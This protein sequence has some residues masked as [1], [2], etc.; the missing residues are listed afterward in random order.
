LNN[1]ADKED[2]QKGNDLKNIIN[3]NYLNSAE[4][5]NDKY[6]ENNKTEKIDT[7]IESSFNQL[8]YV[9][10][11]SIIN[12]NDY[13]IINKVIVNE[14]KD[15][16]NKYNYKL[17]S[18]TYYGNKTLRILN[19]LSKYINEKIC[20]N[21]EIIIENITIDQY[22]REKK[23]KKLR[24]LVEDYSDTYYGLRDIDINKN[25]YRTN[26]LGLVLQGDIENKITQ[27]DGTTASYF[28]SY[29]GKIKISYSVT[30]IQTNSHII[31]RNTNEMVKCFINILYDL[32]KDL[33][34][35]NQNYNEIILNFEKNL[36]LLIDRNNLYDFSRV[37]VLPLNNMYNEV[38]NFTSNL[39]MDLLKIID[40][41][42]SNYTLLFSEIKEN[43]L[44]LF[45]EIKKITKKEYLDYIQCSMNDLENFKNNTLKYINE[46]EYLIQN[47]SN[48]QIDILYD[49]K[50]NIEE[51]K[52]IFK[53]F[54]TLLFNS[55]TKGIKIIKI[56]LSEYMDEIIGELL[57]ITEFISSGLKN[58]DI[59]KN[60][61]DENAKIKTIYKLQEFKII[62]ES[63]INTLFEEIFDEYDKEMLIS[64]IHSIKYLAE[65]KRSNLLEEINN[66]SNNLIE[67]IKLKIKYI[68]KYEL[69]S[70]NIDKINDINYNIENQLYS[71]AN[72][73][74][75]KN[76][77]KIEPEFLDE[78]SDI[79]NNK[80]KLF[81]ISILLKN[82]INNDIN[83]AN[84]YINT[85][86]NKYKN[87][88]I[89]HLYLNLSHFRKSFLDESMNNLL[90][91]FYKLINDTVKIHLKQAIKYNYDLGFEY[92]N[93]ELNYFNIYRH[94]RRE[95]ITTEFISKFYR[96]VENNKNFL[97]LTYSSD[98]IEIFEENFYNLRDEILKYVKDKISSINKYYFDNKLYSNLF[99]YISQV[100]NEILNIIDNINNY[101][102]EIKFDGE[103]QSY[104]INII[105]N[106]LPKYDDQLDKEFQ[107]LYNYIY[108]IS[109]KIKSDG[110]DFCW[111][112]WRTFKGWKNY[113]LYTE[114]T[115]NIEKVINNLISTKTYIINNKNKIY[116]NF[117]N[118][119]SKYLNS[120]INIS[121]NIFTNLFSYMENKINNCENINA[122]LK[123]Y[124]N[125]IYFMIN[126]NS[127]YELINQLSKQQ[128]HNINYNI[129]YTLNE[130]KNDLKILENEY[131]TNYYL[132]NK[133]EFLEYPYEIILKCKQII[134]E[135]DN[136]SD[137]I[138]AT[139]NNRYREK[140]IDI[141]K[142]TN[143]FIR[144]IN[145][146]NYYY[147][148][149]HLN[150]S[151]IIKKYINKKKEV[152]TLN[153][154][155]YEILLNDLEIEV[156]KNL[157]YSL[158]DN[159]KFTSKLKNIINKTQDFIYQFKQNINQ[160]FTQI[161][162]KN[163]TNMS[164]EE[165]IYLYNNH[166]ITENINDMIY[167]IN[168]DSNIDCK[169]V[170]F[171]SELNY[172]KYNFQI[173]KIRNAL[174]YTK[175]LYEELNFID[176]KEEYQDLITI[177]NIK[178]ED[179]KINDKNIWIIYNESLNSLIDL[180]EESKE[181]LKDYYDYFN[182]DFIMDFSIINDKNKNIYINYIQ[183][184][185]D[186]L[187]NK[188][189]PF[190]KMLNDDLYKIELF[191]NNQ[192]DSFNDILEKYFSK[193]NSTIFQKF[194]YYNI[195]K[196]NL[197]NY[198]ELFYKYLDNAFNSILNN[199]NSLE[200]DYNFH[201]AFSY[202]IKN[203]FNER[204][205]SYK[206]VIQEYAK[207]FD[208]HLLN[209]T[210]DLDEYIYNILYKDFQDLEFSYIYSYIELYEQYQK[211]YLNN[212]INIYSN[213][214]NK[215]ISKYKEYYTNFIN[216]LVNQENFV[217]NNF[218]FELK[219]NFTK[220][221]NYSMEN[222]NETI[223]EDSIMWD[224]YQNYLKAL[225][226][227]SIQNNSI[228]NNSIKDLE[229]VTYFNKTKYLL[230]CHNNNYFNYTYYIFNEINST[231]KNNIENIINNII[232]EINSNQFDSNYIY[233]F[234]YNEFQVDI[235]N[236]NNISLNDLKRSLQYDF[237]N[238]QDVCE[239]LS[240]TINKKY[241]R[242]L[243]QIFI[244]NYK[245]SYSIFINNYLLK[246]VNNTIYINYFEEINLK[247][248][249]ITEKLI[250]ESQ[251]YNYLLNHSDKLGI[252]TEESLSSLYSSLYKKI[253]NSI[254]NLLDEFFNYELYI[255]YKENKKIFFENFANYLIKQ[256]GN[257]NSFFNEIFKFN[258]SI[259][260][261]INNSTF[262]KSLISI[263]SNLLNMNIISKIK[264]YIYA[265][266]NKK[267]NDLGNLLNNLSLEMEE[268]LKN[269]SIL[270]Y[271]ENMTNIVNENK[272][273][274]ELVISQNKKF[275][276]I[277]SDKPLNILDNFTDI[278]LR[279]PL[280]EI[281]KYYNKIEEEL[282]NKI[283]LIIENFDDIYGLIKQ[284]LNKEYKIDNIQNIHNITKDLIN[285]YSN[286]I[287]NEILEIKNKLFNFTYINGLNKRNL[288]ELNSRNESRI[289]SINKTNIFND[290]KITKKN[291]H[292]KIYNNDE[293]YKNRNLE[294]N[295]KDGCYNIY[296]IIKAFEMV[297]EI[298]SSFC[299]INLSSDFKRISN[300]LNI[301]IQKNE[302]FLIQL[303]R[304]INLSLL[305]FSNFLTPEKL[306]SL[307]KKIYSQYYLINPY[308][309][310]YL[311]DIS[312]NINIFINFLNSTTLLYD[313]LFIHLNSTIISI[314]DELINLI[315]D[316]YDI[317][318][319]G[320]IFRNLEKFKNKL[321]KNWDFSITLSINF[322]D[323][324]GLDD[325]VQKKIPIVGPLAIKFGFDLFAGITLEFGVEKIFAG[326]KAIYIDLYQQV[327]I[328]I[329]GEGGIYFDLGGGNE[330]NMGAGF[331]FTLG[332]I[333]TGIK[334]EY[335]KKDKKHDLDI[336]REYA[337]FQLKAYVYI[338]FKIK[339]YDIKLT[340]RIELANELY[341]GFKKTEE[342]IYKK[343]HV[344]LSYY[345]NPTIQ[346]ACLLYGIIKKS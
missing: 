300:N 269:I 262:N 258:E 249:Y 236:N 320:T 151:F 224:K 129:N 149:T 162:C 40:Q 180:N 323:N 16:F 340:I 312:M 41:A 235:T 330:I 163:I 4:D 248:D 222:I 66:N 90:N 285:N 152:I 313:S 100:T 298:F 60:A 146:N 226:L 67:S 185:N 273:Y 267:I 344:L 116:Q 252:T 167:K 123:Q 286:I 88:N 89:F 256:K 244:D 91:D 265:F 159:S 68:E 35:R 147:I 208:F 342:D 211:L 55:I 259:D 287:T 109:D 64:N 234:F 310:E 10:N 59:L 47:I 57:Y 87:E 77:T 145:D 115:N 253:N 294:Y 99:Y 18:G 260:D 140:M 6:K 96:F 199:I 107:N 280:L 7:N 13:V 189:M 172:S 127:N 22:K 270:N 299:K 335:K 204:F 241:I 114:H 215:I 246:E 76:I 137:N 223:Y 333:K 51:A 304:T 182:E 103:I 85:Y 317:I 80:N 188:Y 82:E 154:E 78:A 11:E 221:S 336:Y 305:K 8:K 316:K 144:R 44:F 130:I 276:F 268:N 113:Y 125:I 174:Y 141:I 119:F 192:L 32:E 12:K 303:E 181:I 128:I 14:L 266:I 291:N 36:S 50:D 117:I 73:K 289:N 158:L 242:N 263:S 227:N 297:N 177:K 175:N 27:R 233:K 295:S 142:D 321:R 135:L 301:F 230:Y 26:I 271:S 150:Y 71:N 39:F 72:E 183:I 136:N 302:K 318:N 21:K 148:M 5:N 111:S 9:T 97:S 139:I 332:S 61:L 243:H 29:Y 292:Q 207:E 79:I 202:S 205:I 228:Y 161:I 254:D 2:N 134:K 160:E 98:L 34:E 63:I 331:S 31:V 46:L 84:D 105:Q 225:E 315:N 282:L 238:F 23:E 65:N 126:N 325:K 1:N 92:L 251:Y 38:K 328:S 48:F 203:I 81:N 93:D 45:N 229:K 156:V 153:F 94:K 217:S 52:K 311:N 209:I 108:S 132:K 83:I 3:E 193:I 122:I 274:N 178:E 74:I 168:N 187:Q 232:I 206:E 120:C 197:I 283:F 293:N 324:T 213:L 255:F 169:L 210:L 218:I 307:E 101:Y 214:K 334:Y 121:Q 319:Y 28:H 155:L 186:I 240:Y 200:N 58:D 173:V 106:T 250:E 329:F 70:S 337:A 245:I 95:I 212:L 170:N 24:K 15:Y 216:N 281:K 345:P 157:K 237:E 75:I 131:Y 133:T 143:N 37:F 43:N 191:I 165:N 220:C 104:I 112:R 176:K 322:L 86:S 257:K 184:L 102:H 231:I 219:E 171:E 290:I 56:D 346:L 198:F 261:L 196:K 341:K 19:H 69:Y 118:K 296:H 17:Y 306:S 62:I 284:K 275:S 124:D 314:Y 288:N 164:S 338:E 194:D 54:C 33:I 30:D 278:Y 110:R 201:N 42:H 327:S 166:N 272:I 264:E 190:S 279:P 343:I 20:L 326:D 277:V 239:Y 195:D 25:A 179:D 309:I 138:K 53:N 49:I 308:V 339:I 247:L